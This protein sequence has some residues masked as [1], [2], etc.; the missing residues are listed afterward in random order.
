MKTPKASDFFFCTKGAI[1]VLVDS[2]ESYITGRWVF[3][4]D[5][6]ASVQVS[7]LRNVSKYRSE[8]V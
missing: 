4:E 3:G 8:A 7:T 5:V 1:Q 2:T 6:A